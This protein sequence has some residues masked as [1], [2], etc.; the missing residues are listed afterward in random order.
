MSAVLATAMFFAVAPEGVVAPPG[1]EQWQIRFPSGC[2]A[3]AKYVLLPMDE[4]SEQKYCLRRRN[5]GRV[6]EPSEADIVSPI[7]TA[8][9]PEEQGNFV[10]VR[11]MPWPAVDPTHALLL[12]IYTTP[13]R[14]EGDRQAAGTGAKSA[15]GAT[16]QQALAA[17][18]RGGVGPQ[19]ALLHRKNL[20]R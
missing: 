2:G 19:S 17:F 15:S 11:P 12:L 9:E 8:P 16:E 14:E 7:L 18:L 1:A 13:C 20:V 5:G 4:V 6:C 3:P 10:L